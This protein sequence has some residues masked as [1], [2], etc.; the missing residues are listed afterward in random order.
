MR[1]FSLRSLRCGAFTA[2]PSLRY[3]GP[4]WKPRSTISAR[5]ILIFAAP[6]A[7]ACGA[8]RRLAALCGQLRRFAD[9]C[10]AQNFVCGRLR[11][12]C[13]SSVGKGTTRLVKG[14]SR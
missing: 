7:E 12:A 10:G 9:N 1:R 14:I 3:G 6:G 5:N 11:N 4:V 8:L 13:G 2:E